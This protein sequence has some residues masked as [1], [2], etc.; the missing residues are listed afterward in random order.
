MGM[1]NDFLR[2]HLV[3]GS[4]DLKLAEEMPWP[5]PERIFFDDASGP[6]L[7]EATDDDPPRLVLHRVSFSQLTDEQAD[8]PHLAR[9]AEYRYGDDIQ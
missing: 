6:P 1:P 9:G 8:S 7:R 4:I 2:L 5:P 3:V